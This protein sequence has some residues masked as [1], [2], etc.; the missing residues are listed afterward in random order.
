MNANEYDNELVRQLRQAF[1]NG[2]TVGDLLALVAAGNR[3]ELM[4][5]LFPAYFMRAFD[6]PQKYFR[7]LQAAVD[8]QGRVTRLEP[9]EEV[10]RLIG[11][12]F[13]KCSRSRKD[14]NDYGS[15]DLPQMQDFG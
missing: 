5:V 9:I 7:R 6:L 8:S 10:Q 12:R 13:G 11:R 4:P 3:Q 15:S 1:V 14:W 2:A